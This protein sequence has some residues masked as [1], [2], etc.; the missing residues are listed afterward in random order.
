M[1]GSE[2]ICEHMQEFKICMLECERIDLALEKLA[3]FEK[4]ELR[5]STKQDC[6]LEEE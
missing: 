6:N 3:N 5:G 1:R 2:E 4:A